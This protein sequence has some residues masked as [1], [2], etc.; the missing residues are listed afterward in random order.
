MYITSKKGP[1]N[2]AILLNTD[3]YLQ[4][5]KNDLFF[6]AFNYCKTLPK[7]LQGVQN[8]L[9]DAFD[10]LDLSL[11]DKGNL[12]GFRAFLRDSPSVNQRTSAYYIWG[13]KFFSP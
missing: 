2:F 9:V 5:Q 4:L 3:I 7:L 6:K 11:I 8:R 13:T 1:K 12:V 10:V